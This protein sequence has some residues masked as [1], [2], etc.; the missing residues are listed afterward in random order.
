M[1]LYAD[2]LPKAVFPPSALILERTRKREIFLAGLRL[3]EWGKYSRGYKMKNSYE[4]EEEGL[5]SYE[6]V[7]AHYSGWKA[8]E[9]KRQDVKT[10]VSRYS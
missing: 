10:M 6:I 4:G 7:F 3:T 5:L 9:K 8:A 2:H 1:K